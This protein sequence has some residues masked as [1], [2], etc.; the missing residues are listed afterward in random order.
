MTNPLTTTD[1][2]RWKKDVVRNQ[3]KKARLRWRG[4]RKRKVLSKKDHVT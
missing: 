3:R 2:N 1:G 4:K